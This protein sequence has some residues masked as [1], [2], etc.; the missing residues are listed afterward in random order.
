MRLSLIMFFV[1]FFCIV[2]AQ[3]NAISNQNLFDTIPF[4]P[5]HTIERLK[6][7]EKEPIVLGKIIFLGNSITEGGNWKELTGDQTVINRGIGGDIT[8]GLLRRLDDVIKRQP[9]KLF[10]L[11]GINDIGKDLPDAVIADNYRK[12]IKRVQQESGATQI[13]I[14]SILPLNSTVLGFPQH[15]DKLDHVIGT[16]RLL[17]KIAKDMK[18]AFVNLYP[19]FLDKNNRLDAKFTSD[20][21]HL[22]PEGYRIW[23]D[24]LKAKKYLQ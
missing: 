8:Y 15:Y 24:Y 3:R 1:L 19:L 10:I 2:N 11:I 7:F 21:L 22:K 4:I 6:I 18:C 5:D 12:I 20:G 23:V 9:S 17:E 16:N 13:Y 14:Q